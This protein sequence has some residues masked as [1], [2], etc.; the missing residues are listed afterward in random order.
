ME[1]NEPDRVALAPTTPT[2]PR[3]HGFGTRGLDRVPSSRSTAGRFGRMF[4]NLP[5]R[6]LREATLDML[7]ESMV[8]PAEVDETTGDVDKALG[9]PDEDENL[10][11]PAGYTYFGQFVD[12]DITFD[13]ASS[14]QRQNDPDALV[15]FRTPR[16][17]LDSVYG[18]GPADQPYLYHEDGLHLRLGKPVAP[19]ATGAVAGP[20]LPRAGTWDDGATFVPD[21]AL[22]GDPRNDENVLVS[23][24]HVVF[25]KF[26]NKIVDLALDGRD[27]HG[28]DDDEKDALFKDVQRRVRW[29]YQWVVVHDYLR[30]IVGKSVV[31]DILRLPGTPKAGQAGF[32]ADIDVED[33]DVAGMAAAADAASQMPQA[34]VKLCFFKWRKDPYM[35]VEF[36]VAAY[37]FGHSMVR[38]SYAFNQVVTDD[39]AAKHAAG[40][41]NHR[42]A[43]FGPDTE[44]PLENL[45]GFQPL[46]PS[47]GVE[48][49][50]LLPGLGGGDGLP[51]PSYRIDTIL[52][53]PLGA[54]PGAAV[55][56]LR[57]LARRNLA[58]GNTFSLPSGQ[59]VA[60][61]MGLTALTDAELGLDLAGL[62][63]RRAAA[64]LPE[65]PA[66]E[67]G[68][69]PEQ[70]AARFE[71]LLESAAT[72]LEGNA[73]L[74]FYV[75]KEAEEKC[76]GHR[77][78]PVGGRIV[79]EVLIGLLY[80]DS[81]SW[82]NVNPGW[83]P[84]LPDANADFD[85]PALVQFATGQGEAPPT[86]APPY[87]G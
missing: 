57:S 47:W 49:R 65:V 80:G 84:D 79:A 23:Q 20:D 38:P 78:G 81:L 25:L 24:L 13:P 14:L 50:F 30:R 5:V 86:D 82:V 62:K 29:H 34:E 55:A 83:V 27:P 39:L 9:V 60:R 7:A 19:L 68:E 3:P 11:I 26:H 37:R 35:P 63:D 16:F 70:A 53:R 73:P 32:G 75:L 33:S 28:L 22:L 17:D 77:L 85:L 1:P 66:P 71:A 18:R 40:S 48:W 58:R 10:H 45:N 41:H 15:D 64:E 69:T 8:Q 12:H 54:L 74:W 76:D 61:T 72:D 2:Q 56:G 4:R 43:V 51:Q 6:P 44:D 36:S 46:R 21:R 31:D 52:A 87:G 59:A 42:T 67:P